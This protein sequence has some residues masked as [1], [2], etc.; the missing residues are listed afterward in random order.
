MKSKG[1]ILISVTDKQGLDRFRRLTDDGWQIVSTGGTAKTLQ[2]A[3][4]PVTQVEEVTG[5]PEML[6]G[7]VKTLHPMVFGGILAIRDYAEHQEALSKHGIQPI[8]IV[9]VNLYDF[10]HRPNV[11]QIDIGGPSLVRA[12]A[13]NGRSVIIVVDPKD[14]DWVIDSVITTGGITDTQR[15]LL[16]LKAFECTARY[17]AMIVAWMKERL[18]AGADFLTPILGGH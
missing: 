14:Y 2:A 15:E 1:R 6:N 17:E 9:V 7:R 13:K 3:G 10:A 18:A 16:V 8:D 4:I 12:A 11:E 5:F